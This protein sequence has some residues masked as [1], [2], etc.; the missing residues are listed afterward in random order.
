MPTTEPL[1]PGDDAEGRLKPIAEFTSATTTGTAPRAATPTASHT[2]SSVAPR[3]T[4]SASPQHIQPQPTTHTGAPRPMG[5]RT[6]LR[7]PGVSLHSTNT[8]TEDKPQTPVK[9]QHVP[10]TE[11]FTPDDLVR[12]WR[13]FI[14]SNAPEHLLV[15]AMRA[16]IP[17]PAHDNVYNVTQSEVH[18]A[19]IRDNLE[20]LTAYLRNALNNDSVGLELAVVSEDSPLAWNDREFVNH[21]IADDPAM[22][23]F[24]DIL[25]LSLT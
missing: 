2:A 21:L 9:G 23:E 10:R 13:D 8:T 18:I 20:R 6:T 5:L 14:D 3:P 4:M 16:A 7:T 24:I 12:A 1:D 11:P 17:K 19:L 22:N 25:K 15:N